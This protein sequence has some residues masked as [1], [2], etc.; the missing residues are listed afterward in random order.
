[1][2]IPFSNI[3]SFKVPPLS[4]RRQLGIHIFFL[5]HLFFAFKK[6]INI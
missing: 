6:L 1:M 2:P 5:S 4:E 3:H